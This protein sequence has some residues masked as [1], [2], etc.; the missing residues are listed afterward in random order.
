M[1]QSFP[2]I[3]FFIHL[4]RGRLTENSLRHMKASPSKLFN[5]LHISSSSLRPS[6][7]ILLPAS[8]C[9]SDNQCLSKMSEKEWE[10]KKVARDWMGLGFWSQN[11]GIVSSFPQKRET[12]V[13][14]VNE[15]GGDSCQQVRW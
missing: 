5:S 14:C 1:L 13:Y 7:F 3:F 4:S 15:S 2:V 9:E 6:F 12:A 8:V 11:S 10:S